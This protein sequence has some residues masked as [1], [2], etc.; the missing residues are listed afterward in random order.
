MNFDETDYL[1]QARARITWQFEDSPNLD[2]LIKIWLE[3]YQDLQETLLNIRLINDV[4]T[5]SGAQLD[6][7][8]EIVGQP[9]QLINVSATGYFGFEEDPGAKSFGSLKNPQGGFYYGLDDPG[10]GTIILFDDVYRTFIKAKIINNNAG[11]TPEEV[12]AATRDI[13]STS[14]VEL[15][16]G[17]PD[18]LEGA[19]FAL[20][21]GRPWNDTNLT[22]F[23]GL[24]ETDI[25]NRLLPKPAGVRIIYIDVLVGETLEVVETWK[26]ASDILYT[27]ANVTY[28]NTIPEDGFVI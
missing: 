5:A 25:A 16:E 8:G 1:E 12:I 9:R 27:L 2:T 24:D 21:I 3:G 17:D 13:F 10:S 4:D 18:D 11:G 28:L 14:T 19:I 6:V 23:P 7:I 20:G 22:V 15:L 26:T